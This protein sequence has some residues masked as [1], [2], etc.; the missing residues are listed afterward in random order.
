ME[1]KTVMPPE[2]IPD[3]VAVYRCDG[4][5]FTTEEL[6]P[7][8]AHQDFN[9]HFVQWRKKDEKS[10]RKNPVE[11]TKPCEKCALLSKDLETA[12]TIIQVVLARGM[13]ALTDQEWVDKARAFITKA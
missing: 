4:C 6:A 9:T 7:A 12:N 13:G 3:D 8:V 10:W 1:T 11:E 2:I 5:E